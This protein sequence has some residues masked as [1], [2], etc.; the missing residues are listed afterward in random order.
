ML[1]VAKLSQNCM[2][3]VADLSDTHV[4]CC[5]NKPKLHV[6]CCKIKPKLHVGCCCFEQN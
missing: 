2:L 4:G 6:G 3:D 1:L 5:K